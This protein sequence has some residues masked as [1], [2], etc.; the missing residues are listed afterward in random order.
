MHNYPWHQA[1]WQTIE[2]SIYNNRLAHALL[3]TGQA[4]LG[5]K[6]FASDISASVLCQ[7]PSAHQQ[8]CGQC[9]SCQ[10]IESE[11][12]P[13]VLV[14]AAEAKGKAIKVDQ[15]RH[16]SE[17]LNQSSQ[18]AGYKVV[19]IESAES[20]NISA[21]N[22]LLKSL[23]EPAGKSL[24]ILTTEGQLIPTITSR[25]SQINFSTPE[26]SLALKW[27]KQQTQNPKA[28]KALEYALGRLK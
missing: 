19:I 2:K 27:L 13:D 22:A 17:V 3:L 4:G 8:A 7:S 1:Q 21:S 6:Q 24:L 9:N 14:V 5:K 18:K 11:S 10:L 28:E 23:E 16:V 25:C 20:M 26:K 12:H 15:I